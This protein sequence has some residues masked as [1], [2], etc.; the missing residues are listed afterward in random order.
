MVVT[1]TKKLGRILVEAGNLTEDQLELALKEQKQTG[2]KLGDILSRLGICTR[3]EIDKVFASQIGVGYVSLAEEWIKRDAIDL[4]PGEYAEKQMLLPISLQGSTLLLAMADPLDLDTIDAVGRMTGHYV[5]VV[6]ATE[7]DIQEAHRKYYGAKS[8]IDTLMQSTIEESRAAAANDTPLSEAD[9]PYIRLVDLIIEKAVD[10][11]ATDIHIEPEEKVVHI[12][13]RIDGRLVQGPSLARELQSIV[14]TRVKIMAGLNISKTRIPQDG[15][16]QYGKGQ[17]KT[18]LRVSTLPTVHGE[19]IVCRVLDKKN[20]VYGLEKLGMNRDMLTRFR[21]DISRPHGMILVTGPTGSGKTT[22]LYSALTYLNKPD[23][24][25]ITLEDPVEYELSIISQAQIM[26]QQGFTFASGLRAILRQDPDILL[27]GEIRDTE[28][29]QLAIRAALTGHLVFSTL[30]TNTAAGAI[31]RLIDMG[32]EPFL[33]S[34]TLI[35]VLAQR[36]VRSVCPLCRVREEPTEDQKIL[37]RLDELEGTPRYSTGKG[38]PSCKHTGCSGRAAVFEYLQVDSSIRRLISEGASIDA[39]MEKAI[40]SDMRTL[41]QDA[42]EKLLSGKT[43]L[44]EVMRV[45]S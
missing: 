33:L 42:M 40:E 4:V 10:E 13:Y 21:Q 39:I 8:D 29:A 41:R 27:I 11:G 15:R 35:S 44:S 18:D 28:T 30:H 34:A 19:T 20:L 17:D 7:S 12:R 5:E 25:I 14:T 43:S 38:C 26:A 37:L 2:E 22:T 31:P 1:K 9:S 16:I 3:E 36:L 23:T 45:V 24:K 32:I 6:Y